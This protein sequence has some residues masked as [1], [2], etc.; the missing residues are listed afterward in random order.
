M[1]Q[2]RITVSYKPSATEREEL[3]G[4]WMSA[5]ISSFN[6]MSDPSNAKNTIVRSDQSQQPYDHSTRTGS[7]AAARSGLDLLADVTEKSQPSRMTCCHS[8]ELARLHAVPD[9]RVWVH[10]GTFIRG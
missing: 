8:I 3:H 5:S 10:P 4:A 2:A 6:T 7:T 9:S 1:V